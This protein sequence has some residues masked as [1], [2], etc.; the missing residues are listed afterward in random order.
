MG[1]LTEPIETIV[2]LGNRK[3]RVNAAF[4]VVLDVQRLYKEDLPDEVKIE[5]ALRML[6]ENRFRVWCLSMKGKSELLQEIVKQHIDLP[7]RPPSK[8][9]QRLIDFELDGEYIFA[10]FYQDY[11]I[12][13]EKEQGLLHWKKFIALFQGL[14]YKTKIKEIMRIRGMDI[15]DPTKYNQKERQNIIELKSYYALPVEGGGGQEGLDALFC[16]LEGMAHE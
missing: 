11:G 4:N 13:L 14:S 1:F 5:Q 2:R 7:H 9:N 3:Y 8:S 10:S 6:V 15:P 16:A 12:D